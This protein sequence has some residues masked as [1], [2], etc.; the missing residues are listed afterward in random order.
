MAAGAKGGDLFENYVVSEVRKTL[1]NS[2]E[3]SELW[4]YRNRDAR[5][6]DLVIERDG[7]LTPIEVKRGA[8]PRRSAP[9]AFGLLDRSGLERGTG[10]VVC[11]KER[12]GHASRDC[13]YVPAWVL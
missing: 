11:M 5:E 9:S 2:G 7:T 1:N 6:I 3:N 13:L 8:S 4:F 10:G 12:V